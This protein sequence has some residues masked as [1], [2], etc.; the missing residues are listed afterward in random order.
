MSGNTVPRV[1]PTTSILLLAC[2]I[3]SAPTLAV[4]PQVVITSLDGEQIE[5]ELV[6]WRADSLL[7]KTEDGT[8]EI[9][10][11]KLLRVGRPGK[12]E[13]AKSLGSYVELIDASRLPISEFTVAD[14]VA[15]ISTPLSEKP[16]EIPVSKI[17]FVQ[18]SARSDSAAGFWAELEQREMP[19]DLLVIQK[20]D[21]V[22]LDHLSGVLGDVS[23][24][25]VDFRWDGEEIPVKRS[26]VAALAF[27]HAK[28][29]KLPAPSCW[30]MTVQGARFPAAK[31]LWK[32]GEAAFDIE[33]VTGLRFA[34]PLNDLYEAD[35]S[36]GKLVF[37]SDLTPLKQEWTPR[38]DLPATAELIRLYGLPRR[39]QSFSGSSLS[40]FWPSE[41]P[42]SSGV[43]KPYAK[44][45]ALRSRTMLEYRIPKGM[46]H[47]TA[48]A[49]IDPATANQG[50][51]RLEISA[52]GRLLW[53]G[54][55]AGGGVPME[56]NVP[57]QKTRRL[58]LFV[59]YGTNLDYGDR[60]HLVDAKL[61]K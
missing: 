7:L 2:L 25:V 6:G 22:R 48:L 43:T 42:A 3:S 4:S 39:D 47:L 59:D 61:I 33:T 56:I 55:I 8:R 23:M 26:K 38:I 24:E 40:L 21:P 5:G 13:A 54:E 60:L 44:G 17:R 41:N 1:L 36:V 45:L 51:V 35:Y 28:R 37:L 52:D 14:R 10:P 50:N 30:L 11:S 46:N 49:G 58:R 15:T 32:N 16:L 29:P 57:L 31:V 18:F 19:G 20:G 53:Q 12:R 9:A 27:Y 34:I